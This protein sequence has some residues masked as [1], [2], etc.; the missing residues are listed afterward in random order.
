[1]AGETV[2]VIIGPGVDPQHADAVSAALESAGASISATA[3]L[4]PAW[5]SAEHGAFRAAL[6]KEIV[7]DVG[8]ADVTAST[9]QVLNGAL[10]QALV[11][12]AAV[13]AAPSPDPS[14]APLDAALA[15]QRSTVLSDVL[16]RAELATIEHAAGDGDPDAE[17]PAP[18]IAVILVGDEED[19]AARAASAQQLV[20]LAAAFGEAGLGGVLATGAPVA[21]DVG[22]FVAADRSSAGGA[23]VVVDAWSDVG[24]L[25]V[26]LAAQE[27]RAGGAGLYGSSERGS[28]VPT[29]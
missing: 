8:V 2:V 18:T 9:E 1:L 24:P 22:T 13:A 5:V 26:V 4:S 17:P 10:V 20:R 16:T 29:P 28:L 15:E 7:A 23:S 27:Q 12:A 25:I 14:K 6:A 11:P 3:T 21:D 19:A